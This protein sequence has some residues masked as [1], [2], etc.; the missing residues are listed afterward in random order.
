MITPDDSAARGW[1]RRFTL[2]SGPLKRR[3]DRLQV[4][5][6]VLL[7]LSIVLAP[8]CGVVAA[9]AT[10][11]NY[12]AVA[13]AQRAELLPTE[14]V[15]VEAAPTLTSLAGGSGDSGGST[16]PVVRARATW[17]APDGALR[18]G[19]VLVP[20]GTAAGAAVPVWTDRDGNL[21]RPPLDRAGIAGQA[22]AVGV[23]P[24]IGIPL[25]AWTLY[26]L[27]CHALDAHRERR[28]AQDWAAVEP[29]WKSRLL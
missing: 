18:E 1:L 5:G 10:T 7:G 21:T 9:T 16:V 8:P 2:G 14:A 25:A 13:A 12:E 24:L 20:P 6:R 11:A 17:S 23:L 3:S 19:L 27:L 28:W 26:V 15:L 22:A 4:M 29:E